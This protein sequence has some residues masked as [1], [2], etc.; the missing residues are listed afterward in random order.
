MIV[1]VGN[2]TQQPLPRITTTLVWCLGTGCRGVIFDEHSFTTKRTSPIP[3]EK[4][5]SRA[6]QAAVVC[7]FYLNMSPCFMLG[8]AFFSFQ[9]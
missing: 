5:S 4:Y 9:A 8:L 6:E 7:T 1:V 3:Y 2:S